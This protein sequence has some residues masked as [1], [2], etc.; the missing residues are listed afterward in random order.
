MPML[1]PMLLD[2]VAARFKVVT[3]G[4]DMRDYQLMAVQR[5]RLEVSNQV[6]PPESFN[7]SCSKDFSP[8]GRVIFPVAFLY[9][10]SSVETRHI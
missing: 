2:S 10:S 9:R 8:T 4:I 7:Y 6:L 5:G 1:L 3:D